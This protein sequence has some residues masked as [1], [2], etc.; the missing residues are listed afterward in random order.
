MKRAGV[1]GRITRHG[2]VPVV[3]NRL[4]SG[5]Q[6]DELRE[7]VSGSA[8]VFK[9]IV[10]D[11]VQR[12]VLIDT[13]AEGRY[14]TLTHLKIPD[15]GGDFCVQIQLVLTRT[16]KATLRSR[17]RMPRALLTVIKYQDVLIVGNRDRV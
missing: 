12:R 14:D 15:F 8:G 16:G 2:R 10:D 17:R 5:I 11:V 9:C 3:K 1:I 6:A 7:D 4:A 13:S